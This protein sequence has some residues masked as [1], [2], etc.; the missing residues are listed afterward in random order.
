MDRAATDKGVKYLVYKKNQRMIETVRKVMN[1]ELTAY[2]RELATDYWCENLLVEDIAK[3]YKLSRSAFY[4]TV[5]VIEEK[6]NTYLKYV[7]FYSDDTPPTKG[8]FLSYMKKQGGKG[9]FL[10]N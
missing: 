3:K 7:V 2:E 9:E 10:E 1:N 6:I 5:K 8:D 4:R